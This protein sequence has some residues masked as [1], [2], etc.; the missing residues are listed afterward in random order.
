[1]GDELGRGRTTRGP[2]GC[3]RQFLPVVTSNYA[4][5][6]W[7]FRNV[8]SRLD[9]LLPSLFQVSPLFIDLRRNPNY[10]C[11]LRPLPSGGEGRREGRGTLLLK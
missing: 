4:F 2:K 5:D 11:Q 3:R 8:K 6:E 9:S 7:G 1:M 10:H